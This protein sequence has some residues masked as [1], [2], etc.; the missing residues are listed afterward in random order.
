MTIKVRRCG[1]VRARTLQ[2][3]GIRLQYD[4]CHPKLHNFLDTVE[5]RGSLSLQRCSY[6]LTSKDASVLI[7]YV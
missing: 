4:S 1:D 2:F 5:R 6:V 7:L 3:C